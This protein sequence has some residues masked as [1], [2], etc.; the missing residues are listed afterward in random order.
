MSRYLDELGLSQ[1]WEKIKSRFL[2]RSET[3]VISVLDIDNTPTSDSNNLVS[4]GGV[5]N[6]LDTLH[7]AGSPTT[8]GTANKTAS[9]PFGVVDSTSTSTAYTATVDGITELRDGICVLLQNSVVTSA[10]GFTIDINGLGAKPIYNNLATGNPTTPTVPTRDTTIFNINYTMLFIY[11]STLVEGG[12]WICYR[13]YDANTNTIGYQLRANSYSKAMTDITYRYRILFSS[14]DDKKWVPS[15]TSTSTNATSSRAVCQTPINPFGE[16][17]YYGTTASVAAGSRPAATSLW[18][19]YTL[20]FGYAFNRTGAALTLTSWNPVY[21]KCTPQADGSAIIDSTTPYVQSLPTTEDGKIYIFLGVAYSATAVEMLMVHP[22]YYYKNGAIRLWTNPSPSDVEVKKYNTDSTESSEG[23][24]DYGQTD[25]VINGDVSTIVTTQAPPSAVRQYIAPSWRAMNQKLAEKANAADVPTNLHVTLTST[26]SNNVTTYT[27]DHTYAEITAALATGGI[28][29]VEYDAYL[30]TYDGDGDVDGEIYFHRV[31]SKSVSHPNSS[32]NVYDHMFYVEV[33]NDVDVWT[34]EEPTKLIA[35]A[36]TSRTGV[37]QLNN[38]TNSTST[39]QAATANAV[40]QVMDA[41]PTNVSEL[42][43]DA[44]YITSYTETDPV[45]TTSAAHGITSSDISN[46]N[47][48]TSN[49]GTITGI[50]MNGVSKGTSGVV[51]LGTVITE[52]QDISGK[53]DKITSTDNAIAR[54]DGTQG[55]IQ[56][57]G[58]TI[59]DNDQ[60]TAVKFIKSGGTSSQFLKADGSVDSSDYVKSAAEGSITNG[61]L[62]LDKATNNQ[63]GITILSDTVENVSNKAMTPAGVINAI[64]GAIQGIT[65]FDYQKVVDL[66]QTG[67]KGIIYLKPNSGENPNAFDEYIW[68]EESGE[69]EFEKLGTRDIA[70]TLTQSYTPASNPTVLSGGMTYEEAFRNIEKTIWNN[71]E[72]SAIALN[73]LN[74]RK[75]DKVEGKV[76]S[77]NDYTSEEKTKLDGIAAGAQVNV[78]SD[79]NQTTTTA[80]DYIKNK[81][82][83]VSAFTNDSGYITSS[84]IIDGDSAYGEHDRA[85]SGYSVN[86]RLQDKQDTLSSGVN[87]KTINNE[88]LL[89]S[90]NILTTNAP[91]LKK[92]YE[93]YTC[94]AAN[95]EKGYIYFMNVVPTNDSYFQPWHV[96]YILEIKGAN[97]EYCQGYYDIT[98]GFAGTTSHYRIFNK[99]YSTSYYPS[100]YH[101]MAWYNSA[102][103][104]ANKETYPVKFG[105]RIYSAYGAN[106]EPRTYTIKV[107]EMYNCSVTFPTNIETYDSFYND[108][109]YGYN[110]VWNATSNGGLDNYD[111]NTVPYQYYEH[112]S[113][114]FIHSTETPLYRYKICGFDDDNRLIPITITN[115]TNST[116]NTLTPC[117]VPMS[118]SR[119]LIYYASTTDITTATAR[120]AYG[121]I[122]RGQEVSS[123]TI[124]QYNFNGLP[125][126]SK[127]IYLQGTYNQSQDTFVLDDDYYVVVPDDITSAN[128][129]EYFTTGKYYWYLGCTATSNANYGVFNLNNPLYQ[130]NGSKL[131]PV[132]SNIGTL[133]LSSAI[134]ILSSS[135]NYQEIS[136]SNSFANL[137]QDLVT[138]ISTQLDD[139]LNTINPVTIEFVNFENN[140]PLF[141]YSTN[142]YV[143]K[144]SDQ[145]HITVNEGFL[146]GT[147]VCSKQQNIWGVYPLE[148]FTKSIEINNTTYPANFAGNINISLKTINNESILGSGNIT[149]QGGSSNDKVML[150][151][152][153]STGGTITCDTSINNIIN[154][155]S[156]NKIIYGVGEEQMVQQ[157]VMY[158]SNVVSFR[159]TAEAVSGDLASLI[160]IGYS[161]SIKNGNDAWEVVYYQVADNIIETIKV[162]G[163]ALTPD[164]NKAVDITIPS[165]VTESTVSGWGFT[166]NAGTIT[167]IT[168]NGASKGTSGVVDLGTVLTAHQNIKTIN[169][170]SLVGT[171]N[172]N[173]SSGDINEIEIIKVNG[174]TIAPDSDKVVDITIPTKLEDLAGS[175]DSIHVSQSAFDAKGTYS[176]P[177]GGIPKTDLA[178]A[179]QTSLGLADTALQPSAIIDNTSFSSEHSK[180]PSGYAVNAALQ[181]KA[182]SATTLAGYGIT[183]AKIASGVITLGT[184]TITPITSVKTINSNTITGTG[185]ITIATPG[186]LNTTASLAQSTNNSESLSGSIT[187]H[188]VSKTGSYADLLNTPTITDNT[189]VTHIDDLQDQEINE[190]LLTAGAIYNVVTTA[191]N[192]AKVTIYSGSG[193]PSNSSGS[194]GDLYLQTS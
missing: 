61:Q 175:S 158:N 133:P 129:S 148:T 159:M 106:T 46:W 164:A 77:T 193:T 33:V 98:A 116:Q 52:H 131:L 41:I 24:A 121:T 171:G 66:P 177:S 88:S 48:K 44:G 192:A 122:Y 27:A 64:S 139:I 59:D 142:V 143:D 49:V 84:Y 12:A 23:T 102:A 115:R 45:F 135:N 34:F 43:N 78:Q 180:A 104:Y 68:I 181:G 62:T 155:A 156:E 75:L 119:G 137:N 90:G 157:L 111:A 147:I 56:N 21:I 31:S 154:A 134:L 60:V 138:I 172:I 109:N 38:T 22:V 188:K 176:K 89:G 79:W 80:N 125:G 120:T 127:Q 29:D 141:F 8:G 130:F 18:Q 11:H 189:E 96:H 110:T 65:Q 63:Y 19:Q 9:I 97:Q 82:T 150:V 58:V 93:N 85:P 166:K 71:E 17:V 178:S 194:N 47:S 94:A 160:S 162:N 100:Y 87:I 128:Y 36:S 3:A 50:N 1:F 112:Y 76:L 30:Y 70:L 14:A 103:K 72:I 132:I 16:I 26:T 57:S 190:G 13:G 28:V 86:A 140:E 55:A 161:G 35:N 124:F 15:T 69:G 39:T 191:I 170:Q 151:H 165:A 37:V 53:V 4:S 145:I 168:M 108:T 117:K 123:S 40:K 187:L 185:N 173:I 2:E 163:T 25:V 179:V 114:Y 99:F 6:A 10:S 113:Q 107:I 152:F 32:D 153:S 5:K 169:N 182:D 95:I 136:T 186:T 20:T 67:S 7:Y 149:I 167:G 144:S 118:V 126:T 51:D 174:T 91:L 183:D 74:N 92:T 105:E 42:T 146:N 81:P 184:N 83:N 54:F 73:D 101:L